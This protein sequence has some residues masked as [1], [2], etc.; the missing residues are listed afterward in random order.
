MS[1]EAQGQLQ[2]IIG[3]MGE[4]GAAL[5]PQV[6]QAMR[7]SLALAISNVFYYAFFAI[8]LAFIVN[9]FLREIPLRAHHGAAPQHPPEKKE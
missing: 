2:A 9:L 4:Q 3:Q 5:L 1:P 8:V 6:M 7:E